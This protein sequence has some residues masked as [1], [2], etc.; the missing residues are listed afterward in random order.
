MDKELPKIVYVTNTRFPTEKAHGLATVKLCEALSNLGHEVEIIAPSLWRKKKEGVFDYYDVKKNFKIFNIFTIDLMPFRL[1]EKLAFL[2]QIFSFSKSALLY[3]LVKYRGQKNVIF[4]SHDYIPLYFLTFISKNIFYDVHHFPGKNFMYRRVMKKSFGFAVQTKWKL[5]ALEQEWK[6]HSDKMIYWPN[7]TDVF[8]MG[9]SKNEARKSLDLPKERKMV[10]YTGQLFGWKGVDT[11]IRAV[12]IINEDADVYIV[13]GSSED[14]KTVR[15]NIPQS[16]NERIKFISFQPHNTIPLWLRSAD[17]L[18]LPN[19][20][21]QKVSL[22]YTSPM[23]LFEYMASGTPIVASN[24]PSITE[25]L[26]SESAFLA[27]PDNP[28]S[29]GNAINDA[30]SDYKIAEKKASRAEEEVKKYTW[31][32]RARKISDFIKTNYNA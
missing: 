8:E 20:A 29:F 31:E 18:V 14:V 23:K 27:E 16:N 32:S 26:D 11:L 12:D 4:F 24:I 15:K 25:I 21:K 3:S 2:V 6:I 28:S 9:I 5:K 10:L 13:G 7:G 30:L 22:Y 1:P 19:T 17:I